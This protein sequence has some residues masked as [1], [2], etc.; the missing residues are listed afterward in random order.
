MIVFSLNIINIELYFFIA[1]KQDEETDLTDDNVPGNLAKGNKNLDFILA[2][3]GELFALLG[4]I[5][6]GST[7]FFNEEVTKII[8]ISSVALIIILFALKFIYSKKTGGIDVKYRQVRK[9]LKQERYIHA[10]LKEEYNKLIQTKNKIADVA[11]NHL[12]SNRAL[13]GNV[14]EKFSKKIEFNEN[15]RI[16]FFRFN[17]NLNRFINVGKHSQN[18]RYMNNNRSDVEFAIEEMDMFNNAL[19]FGEHEVIIPYD[20][21]TQKSQYSAI[22]GVS[23]A[24]AKKFDMKSRYIFI[25]MVN[26]TEGTTETPVGAFVFESMLVDDLPPKLGK[27]KAEMPE[28]S[29]LLCKWLLKNNSLDA[30]ST[31]SPLRTNVN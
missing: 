23:I 18:Y 22:L 9:D 15:H 17:S 1:M 28:F 3:S 30:E 20:F 26:V 16:S 4:V 25:K 5:V 11:K 13:I 31:Y 2:Y 24:E 19:T 21:S 27:I 29:G 14:L 8:S 12:N 10:K 6:S 7:F